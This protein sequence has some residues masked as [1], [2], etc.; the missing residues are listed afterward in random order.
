MKEEAIQSIKRAAD[1]SET[2]VREMFDNVVLSMLSYTLTNPDGYSHLYLSPRFKATLIGSVDVKG[3]IE[4]FG[5]AT[6]AVLESLNAAAPFEDVITDY[7]GS[8]L[9]GQRGQYMT[10]SDL[11]E[12]VS[13]YLGDGGESDRIADPTCGTGSLI[14]GQLRQRY[15]IQGAVGLQSVEIV[16]NDIDMRLLRIAVLQVMFHTIKHEAPVASVK[17]W[18][19]DLI[20]EYEAPNK[21]VL[22]CSSHRHALSV[23]SGRSAKI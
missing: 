5:A 3:A 6:L 10:P 14:L 23:L 20:R 15:E 13:K 11:S 12:A 21:L 17:A 7:Y 2:T 19:A 4:A 1:Q 8:L 9:V 16:L 22:E 18:Q